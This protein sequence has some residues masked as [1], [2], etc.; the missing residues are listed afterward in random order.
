MDNTQIVL[1]IQ[2]NFHKISSLSEYINEITDFRE[3]ILNEGK[4]ETLYFR[5]QSDSSWDIRPSIFRNSLVSAESKIIQTA[6][7]RV[8]HEFK[9][10]SSSFEELTKLQHYGLPTRLLDVT[11]NPLV[12]LYFACSSSEITKDKDSNDVC[13]DGIVYICQGYEEHEKSLKAKILSSLAKMNI[14]S[15]TTLRNLKDRLDIKENYAPES[16]IDLIQDSIFVMPSY[17]NTR[18]IRQSGAFLITGAIKIIIDENDIWNSK[19]SKSIRNL[20]DEIDK[21]HILI[22][23][24]AKYSILDELDFV[25]IN[26]STLFPELEHQMSHIKRV[27]SKWV[28]SD[29]DF[30]VK[31]EHQSK[32]DDIS[33]VNPKK[34]VSEEM[35]QT[36]LN[37]NIV[38]KKAK[39][40][41]KNIILDIITFPDW[42]TKENI[43]N[44]LVMKIKRQLKSSGCTNAKNV[45]NAV[46]NELINKIQ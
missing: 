13:C 12:A 5:G 24:D 21:N 36:I 35:I 37:K 32:V 8:P 26:E 42:D 3:R 25:N 18:L 19:V 11:M 22:S 9:E 46:V 30:F 34:E 45:A 38:V 33:K 41:I 23:G 43:R 10:C 40:E 2:D 39:P 27:G 16:F 17:S 44:I 29:S 15:G 20:N 1:D 6:M 4:S 28:T 7:A 31:Y 14:T